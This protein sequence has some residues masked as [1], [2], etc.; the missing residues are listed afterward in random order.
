MWW[1][2]ILVYI[3]TVKD[4]ILTMW[5]SGNSFSNTCYCSSGNISFRPMFICSRIVLFIFRPTGPLSGMPFVSFNNCLMQH[6]HNLQIFT[7]SADGIAKPPLSFL[8]KNAMC[9]RDLLPYS[10]SSHWWQCCFY[11][12]HGGVNM[13]RLVSILDS[14]PA[15]CVSLV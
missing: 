8:N 9:L 5:L 13:R 11:L 3:S 12:F 7:M 1:H 6:S 14:T 4:T 15:L 2:L 10:D